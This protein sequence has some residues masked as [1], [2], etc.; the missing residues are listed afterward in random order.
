MK[1][2][3][4]RLLASVLADA[5]VIGYTPTHIAKASGTSKTE[6]TQEIRRF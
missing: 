3:L 4:K 6:E 1:Y 2:L 5:I